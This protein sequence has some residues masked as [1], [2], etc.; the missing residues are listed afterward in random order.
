MRSFLALLLITT[1]WS[2]EVT[3]V[4]NVPLPASPQNLVVIGLATNLGMG[5]YVS[6]TAPFKGSSVATGLL[7][8]KVSLLRGNQAVELLQKQ[9]LFYTTSQRRNYDQ[10]YLLQVQHLTLG[11]AS[12]A[13]ETLPERVAIVK[14]IAT[15]D[16]N[17]RDV[18]VS[19]SLKD[20]GEKN[21]YAY[22]I[23]PANNR[24]PA[25]DSLFYRIS[26]DFL[27]DNLAFANQ[28][29]TVKTRQ[30][31]AWRN[32]AGQTIRA[33]RVTIYLYHLS[34]ATYDYYR[35]LG[36][37]LSFFDDTFAIVLPTKNNIKNGQGFVGACSIDSVSVVVKP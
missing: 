31:V 11:E 15:F 8:A 3:S 12:A 10:E 25:P 33:N 28:T 14:P 32:A 35:S 29:K 19:F 7:E 18:N 23:I 37:Y 6:T 24:I 36:E 27:F 16:K 20:A 26:P 9:S 30:A 2:C 1:L 21:Y 5:V 13:L 34:S 4:K 22:K 17:E